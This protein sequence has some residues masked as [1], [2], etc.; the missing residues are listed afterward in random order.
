MN[1]DKLDLSPLDPSR[2]GERW[3][4]LVQSVASRALRAH[5]ARLTVTGQMLAWARP[6]L[7]LAAAVSLVSWGG[8]LAV[9]GR[10]TQGS[11]PQ[12]EPT[13]QLA[14]WALNDQLPDTAT[15]LTVMGESNVQR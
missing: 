6:V 1:E 2:D 5:R 11:Q 8:A 14:S 13:Q 12:V 4:R 3:E 9:S 10:S 15:I 7:A